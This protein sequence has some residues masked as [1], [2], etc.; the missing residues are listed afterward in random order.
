ML[1]CENDKTENNTNLQLDTQVMEE[2][3]SNKVGRMAAEAREGTAVP[4]IRQKLYARDGS[5]LDE[6]EPEADDIEERTCTYASICRREGEV[7][8]RQEDDL[9]ARE[10]SAEDVA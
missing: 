5:E 8:E 2:W 3:E 7:V 9:Y 4:I 10:P 1:N 6:R